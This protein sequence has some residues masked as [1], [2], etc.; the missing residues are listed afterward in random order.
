MI[1]IASPIT[2]PQFNK[3]FGIKAV[4]QEIEGWRGEDTVSYTNVTAGRMVILIVLCLF[5]FLLVLKL[6]EAGV[7]YGVKFL[8]VV[9]WL[10]IWDIG[11]HM[12]TGHLKVIPL[13]S[14]LA[15]TLSYKAAQQ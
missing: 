11:I 8:S 1:D 7:V 14:L 12:V 3:G 4:A 5:S 2:K 13:Y 15:L 9:D 10:Y 6:L